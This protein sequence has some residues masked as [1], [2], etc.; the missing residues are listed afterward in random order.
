MCSLYIPYNV[1]HRI[2]RS[3]SDRSPRRFILARPKG[4]Q[5]SKRDVGLVDALVSAPS[6]LILTA[7][8]RRKTATKPS[9]RGRKKNWSN[10]TQSVQGPTPILA[11]AFS[12]I[13]I[14]KARFAGKVPQSQSR[15]LGDCRS[16]KLRWGGE[17]FE[18]DHMSVNR[19]LDRATSARK[20]LSVRSSGWKRRGRRIECE[21]RIFL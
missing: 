8:R 5:P 17:G 20:E 13:Q 6:P 14:Q 15:I 21:G 1:E 18:F 4:F 16:S 10:H 9:A 19:S 7:T 3:P 12:S 2:D 11:L